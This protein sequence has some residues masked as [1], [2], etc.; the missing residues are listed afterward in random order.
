MK[1]RFFAILCGAAMMT[2]VACN[3]KEEVTPAAQR[4]PLTFSA[5]APEE[6]VSAQDS[7][8]AIDGQAVTWSKDDAISVFGATSE[9]N[10]FELISGS[11]TATAK[12]SG[13]A[14]PATQYNALYPFSETSSISGDIISSELPAE[15]T[16]VAGTFDT[17]L[18]PA[19]AK[20][21]VTGKTLTFSH[22]TGLLKVTVTEAVKSISLSAEG[23]KMSGKYT[24]DMSQAEYTAAAA[25][26]QAS[27]VTISAADGSDLA[28][29]TYYMAVLPGT[30][31][32]AKLTITPATGDAKTA[33]VESLEIKA[34]AIANAVL[35]G[36]EIE[37]PVLEFGEVPEGDLNINYGATDRTYPVNANVE[38]TVTADSEDLT[39]VEDA[40]SV[41]VSFPRSKYIYDKKYTLTLSADDASLE[42]KTLT[43]TQKACI[44]LNQSSTVPS[45]NGT[46][47]ANGAR[48]MVKTPDM[49]KYGTFIWT[50]S[51]VNITSGYFMVNNW[52]E[53]GIYLMIRFDGADN[54]LLAAGKEPDAPLTING[55]KVH[56]GFSNGWGGLWNYTGQFIED[57][58][59]TLSELETI[60]LVMK[61]VERVGGQNDGSGTK[62]LL[63]ELY[64]N[65]NL[66]LTNQDGTDPRRY[67][68][69]DIWQEGSTHPGFQYEFGIACDDAAQT[70]GTMTIESFEYIPYT[71]AE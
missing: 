57:T 28:A 16:A 33:T 14:V 6:F 24:V 30:Y 67:N 51:D 38:W 13:N 39:I 9:N 10:R 4:V 59:P 44:D 15:Q 71:P 36:G 45:E 48:A 62:T 3:E 23:A 5:G 53:S 32:N 60:K 68:T 25:G 31:A 70:S 69:G 46:I 58:Y 7:K 65:D 56:F 37:E 43:I 54:H 47:A 11:G 64:I 8:T 22:V 42:S 20:S 52:G 17:M 27:G 49:F 26:E 19:A 61:P 21:D 50:F 1:T 41:K 34:G 12:F 29:G 2:A 40:S 63:R 35:S 55:N 18:V 66:V